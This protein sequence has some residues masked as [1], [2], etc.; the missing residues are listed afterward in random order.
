MKNKIIRTTVD[1]IVMIPEDLDEKRVY[2]ALDSG[3]QEIV[4]LLSDYAVLHMSVPVASPGKL[5]TVD[6]NEIPVWV[7]EMWSEH[8]DGLVEPEHP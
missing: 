8:E 7:D 5:T 2:R 6:R 4:N 1:V 3:C